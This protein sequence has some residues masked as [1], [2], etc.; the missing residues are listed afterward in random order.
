[1]MN[2]HTTPVTASSFPKWK[3]NKRRHIIEKCTGREFYFEQDPLSLKWN[4]VT[5]EIETLEAKETEPDGNKRK[6]QS[7][8]SS[9]SSWPKILKISRKNSKQNKTQICETSAD[10]MPMVNIMSLVK[11]HLNKSKTNVAN[12]N[13]NSDTHTNNNF[14]GV[15]IESVRKNIK[16]ENELK[17]EIVSSVSASTSKSI[18]IKSKPLHHDHVKIKLEPSSYNDGQSDQEP[19][20]NCK[21]QSDQEPSGFYAEENLQESS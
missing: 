2:S 14:K 12:N 9:R 18:N 16:I 17:S 19:D 13:E 5:P 15:G 8:D 21:R 20:S 3:S 11:K 7:S 1:M 4:D 6:P 10:S